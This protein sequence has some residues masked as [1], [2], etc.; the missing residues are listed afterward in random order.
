MLT[1]LHALIYCKLVINSSHPCKRTLLHCDL[2]DQNPFSHVKVGCIPNPTA[3]TLIPKGPSSTLSFPPSP[4]SGSDSSIFAAGCSAQ[5][6]QRNHQRLSYFHSS[7]LLCRQVLV[8]GS[9]CPES[10]HFS[11]FLPCPLPGPAHGL[12]ITALAPSWSPCLC[13][14]A[15]RVY[16]GASSPRT[17][18]QRH[19]GSSKL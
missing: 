7:H 9:L 12:L 13:P 15:S 10:D 5:K 17:V 14:C 2:Q 6:P 19:L 8:V 1:T 3:L 4:L 16:S 11:L 18:L